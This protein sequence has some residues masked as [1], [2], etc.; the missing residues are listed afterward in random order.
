MHDNNDILDRFYHP[1]LAN[2]EARKRAKQNAKHNRILIALSI[3]G[4]I[5]AIITILK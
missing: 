3:I 2:R 5:L 4:I 1:V